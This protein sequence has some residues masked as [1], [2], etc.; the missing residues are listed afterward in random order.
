[1]F[2]LQPGEIAQSVVTDGAYSS[3]NYSGFAPD[4]LLMTQTCQPIS[5]TKVNMNLKNV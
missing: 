2:G 5:V 4:S 1:M 3:G